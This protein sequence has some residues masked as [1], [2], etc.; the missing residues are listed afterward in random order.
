MLSLSVC[1]TD[2]QASTHAHFETKVIPVF[3]NNASYNQDV[4]VTVASTLPAA[5]TQR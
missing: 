3:S 4:F 2:G 5:A 1:C